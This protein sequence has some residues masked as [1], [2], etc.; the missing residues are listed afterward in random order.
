MARFRSAFLT[1]LTLGTLTGTAAAQQP[2]REPNHPGRPTDAAAALP[3][4]RTL[5][6]QDAVRIALDQNPNVRTARNNINS[7]R[8]ARRAATA[9]FLPSLNANASAN[10]VYDRGPKRLGIDPITN[11]P[12]YS[13]TDLQFDGSRSYNYSLSSSVNLFNGF[14]DMTLLKQTQSGLA[15]AEQSLDR[16]EQSTIFSVTSAFL[17]VVLNEQLLDISNEQL[18]SS[19]LQF[20]RIQG[21]VGA[22]SRPITDQY[23]QEATVAG[24]ELKVV[25]SDNNVRLARAKLLQVLNLDPTV[26]Y[27]FTIPQVA[28]LTAAM[29][30]GAPMSESSINEMAQIALR[31]RPDVL[32]LEAQIRSAESQ[33]IIAKS[34]FYPSLNLN[35][36]FASGA[37]SSS[38]TQVINGQLSTGA[39]SITDQLFKDNIRF[40]FGLSLSVPIFSN[41]RT[42]QQ[43]VL[44]QTQLSNLKLQ[45]ET[46][47]QQVRLE[48]KQS[49]LDYVAAQKRV[50][51]TNA[52]LT[53]A[54][55][56]YEAATARYEA[57]AG[58][59]T[60]QATARATFQTAQS[61]KAQALYQLIFQRG[62]LDF[63]L[64]RLSPNLGLL[65]TTAP[66]GGVA[67]TRTT[68]PINPA[69]VNPS[70]IP[71]NAPNTT[72]TTTP[73]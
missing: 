35:S 62:A 58:T 39:T 54:Q 42:T 27:T 45:M 52:Q 71:V 33:L 2:F 4:G 12:T 36:S 1:C 55:R 30:A 21:L 37:S 70:G 38:R 41:L 19:Q 15:Q 29:P 48:L 34:Q 46:L 17:Q 10:Q 57:G 73:Q 5:T 31:G 44:Q 28:E 8:I 6:L 13:D 60:E 68:A 16:T 32:S 53:A 47:L 72:P 67:P 22:G 11:R 64:G 51:A 23:Q 9:A 61:Q 56:A 63:Y 50:D 24:D 65:S 20:K 43:V 40:S 25:D 7:A 69:A 26:D 14:S 3:P 18:G 59:Y 49:S 66:T